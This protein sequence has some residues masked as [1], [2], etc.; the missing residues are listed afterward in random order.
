VE[1][2]RREA[3]GRAAPG[4]HAQERAEQDRPR[5]REAQEGTE[6]GHRR[7]VEELLAR[8]NEFKSKQQAAAEEQAAAE[9]EAARI[10]LQLP[11]IP[12]PSWPV[13][14]DDK[15]NVVVREWA[16]P[17]MPPKKLE[18]GQ[19]DHVALGTAWA[20]STSTVG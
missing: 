12:D 5:D 20:S 14:A 2:G 4:R 6:G 9:A 10:M 16:D 19:K 8:S 15:D 7:R 11:A 3:P 13:G 18:A 17:A 1:S